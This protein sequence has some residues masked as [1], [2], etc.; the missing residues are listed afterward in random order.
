MSYTVWQEH[1]LDTNKEFSML[2]KFYKGDRSANTQ[3]ESLIKEKGFETQVVLKRTLLFLKGTELIATKSQ[4]WS[5]ED[6]LNTLVEFD[7]VAQANDFILEEF[8]AAP[9]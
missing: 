7:K 9:E 8:L 6:I 1:G 5:K 4:F 2:F 3:I